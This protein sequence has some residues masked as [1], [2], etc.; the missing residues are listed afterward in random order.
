MKKLEQILENSKLNKWPYPKTFDALIDAGVTAYSVNFKDQ[1]ESIYYGN[2]GS[3]QEDTPSGYSPL[4]IAKIFSAQGVKNSIIK[5][6]Q[7]KTS[8]M[9]FLADIAL[10]GVSHYLVDMSKRIITYYNPDETEF[11][12]ENVPVWN[13]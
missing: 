8:Y 2:F 9:E 12:I 3:F 1:F 13:E 6:I 4:K 7:E 11:H 10:Q 5:H